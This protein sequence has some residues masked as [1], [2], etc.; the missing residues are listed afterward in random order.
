L[1]LALSI[2][3]PGLIVWHVNG[4]RPFGFYP[5]P[6]G[7]DL[8]SLDFYDGNNVNNSRIDVEYGRMD[9]TKMTV[10]VPLRDLTREKAP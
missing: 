9:G 10:A 3:F 7:K 8:S 5:A 6:G 2:T 1:R 4:N